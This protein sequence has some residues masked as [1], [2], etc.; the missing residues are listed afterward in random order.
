[1]KIL[2]SYLFKLWLRIKFGD[3]LSIASNVYVPLSTLFIID[4]SSSIE[5]KADCILRDYIEFRATNESQ[6]I[7]QEQVKLDRFIRIIATNN[8]I[9]N[10]GQGCK[11]GQGTIF[12]GGGNILIGYKTLISGYVYIQTSMHNHHR[13]D[14]DIMV[15]GYLYGDIS[16]G[17]GSWLGVHSVIFPNVSLGMRTIVGSNAVVNKSFDK[18]SIIGGIPAKRIK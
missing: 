3:R 8:S 5:I 6:L 4:S 12:N 2:G 16:I 15:S 10:I 7:I 11:V 13:K 14:K 17:P 1:M 9:V 18:D